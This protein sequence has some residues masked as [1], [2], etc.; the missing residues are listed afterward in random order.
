MDAKN[1]IVIL[2]IKSASKII[3]VVLENKTENKYSNTFCNL[4]VFLNLLILQVPVSAMYVFL[5]KNN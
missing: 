2:A 4:A 3:N 1:V 5:L